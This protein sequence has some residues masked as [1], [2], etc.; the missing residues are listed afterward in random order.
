MNT[1][2]LK[3]GRIREKEAC[4][5]FSKKKVALDQTQHLQFMNFC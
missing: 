5:D 2:G 1:M 3:T 4:Y